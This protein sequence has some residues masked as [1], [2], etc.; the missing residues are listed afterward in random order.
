[1]PRR[2][3]KPARRP[4]RRVR[5]ANPGRAINQRQT[6]AQRCTLFETVQVQ[7]IPSNQMVNY[8]FSMNDFTRAR[9]ASLE[10]QFYRAKKVTYTFEPLYNNY[11][12]GIGA[13]SAPYMYIRMN[14][15][16]D[17]IVPGNLFDL[18]AAG[19]MARRF[20]KTVKITY[21][22]NWTSPG[23]LVISTAAVAGMPPPNNQ[24]VNGVTENGSKIEYGYINNSPYQ[25]TQDPAGA[26]IVPVF[27][28]RLPGTLEA[29]LP[30]VQS[31]NGLAAP[32]SQASYAL[33]NGHYVYFDQ[34]FANPTATAPVARVTM[35]VEWEFKGPIWWSKIVQTNT[36]VNPVPTP[37]AE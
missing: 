26:V 9:L 12:A 20:T 33:Y 34:K 21:R 35:T 16:A 10:W 24:F 28:R 6:Q 1:M 17:S 5:K 22:P 15:T 4:R 18:Q 19:A 30:G 36:N 7:D 13:L 23:Q 25:Q 11:E 37:P 32:P 8:N 29:A 14:R 3:R 27:N 2:A 31:T